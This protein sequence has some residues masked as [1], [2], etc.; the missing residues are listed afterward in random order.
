MKRLIKFR[1]SFWPVSRSVSLPCRAVGGW[2]A[3]LLAACVLWA[4]AAAAR[5]DDE[6]GFKPLF[7]GRDLAG[8]EGDPRFWSV[9]DG[10]VTG[11]TTADNPTK[12]NTFL[13]WR[14]GEV[15]DF[16]LRFS[17]RIVGGNSGV[18]YRSREI[19]KWVVSGYQADFEAGDTYS[20]ILYEER[21]R[22][23][24]AQRGQKTRVGK[25]GKPQVVGKV[26][27]SKEIQSAIRKEDWNDYVITARG[28]HFTHQINGRTTCDVTDEQPAKAAYSGILALQ[29]HAGQPMKVQFKDVR[30]KRLPLSDGRRKIVLVAGSPSHGP[31][32]HEFNA[33]V[34][35]LKHCL[36][37]TSGVVAA[38]YRNGWPKDPTAFDNADSIVFYMDGGGG[39]PLIKGDHLARIGALMKRGVGLACVHYAVEVPKE[40][41]GPELLDWIGGYYET[42]YSINPHWVADFKEMPKHPICRGVKPFAIRDEWYFNIRFRPGMSGVEPILKATPPD[43]VRRTPAAKEHPGREEIVAWAVE[44]PDGGRGFG[45]TGAHFHAN[46]GDD[47]FRKLVLNALVWTAKGDLPPEGID[48]SVDPAELKE[49]LD[50]KG[51]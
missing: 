17:C 2:C 36:D 49:N 27:D 34:I 1:T 16:E 45:F 31:G 41:G 19:D 9:E 50:P 18:Q 43:D 3:V 8:W 51:K 44:R 14:D 37:R 22:G 23:I 40:N 32:E 38:A 26:G 46:W 12:G 33:G 13:I 25:D 28:N 6:S 47:N 4:H 42:G 21:A 30:L 11:R 20:G 7:N 5:A 10:L 15:D 39:H 24:L 29:L 48:S 35:L